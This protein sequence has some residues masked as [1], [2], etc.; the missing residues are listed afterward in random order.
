MHESQDITLSM[1]Y[2]SY[3][4]LDLGIEAARSEGANDNE[5]SLMLRLKANF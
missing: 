4:D 1:I 3:S 2:Y 5:Y